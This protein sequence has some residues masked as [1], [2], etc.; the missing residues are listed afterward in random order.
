[1]ALQAERPHVGEVAFA[2]TFRHGHDVVGVPQVAAV[3]PVLLELA[4]GGVVEL[5]LV[6]AEGF[7]IQACLLYTSDAA[8]E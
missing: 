3:A 7:G 6:F 5:A 1:M 8:D 2:S 4:A